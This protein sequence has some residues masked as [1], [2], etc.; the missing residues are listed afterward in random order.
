MLT[1]ADTGVLV[2]VKDDSV[3]GS[4]VAACRDLLVGFTVMLVN[5]I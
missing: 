1:S 3:G 5:E 4:R 2:S